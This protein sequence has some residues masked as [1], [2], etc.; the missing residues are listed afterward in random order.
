MADFMGIVGG[1]FYSVGILGIDAFHY[2]DNSA[3]FVGA[4]DVFSG[5]LKSLFF[6]AAIAL[7]GCHRGFHCN[8]G[9]EG[10]GRAA[11]TAFVYS[12]VV[13]LFLDFLLGISLEAI[14]TAFVS[15]GPG[16]F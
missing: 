11:T 10:V 13:I 4:F 5:V 3:R 14:H 1:Y 12:F 16:L 7:I 8:A 2:S 6:G 15:Q 9:A